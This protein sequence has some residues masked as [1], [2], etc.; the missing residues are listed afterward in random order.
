MGRLPWILPV[1]LVVLVVVGSAAILYVAYQNN[2]SLTRQLSDSRVRTGELERKTTELQD[3]NRDLEGQ[4]L[5][6]NQ[7]AAQLQTRVGQ[8]EAELREPTKTIWNVAQILE[9]PDSYLAGG[10]PDTFTYHLR[11]RSDAPISVSIISFGQF[12]MAIDCVRL[13]RGNTHYCMHHSGGTNWQDIT[14]L[15]YDF[16]DSEGCA[17]YMSVIT[18]VRRVTVTPDVSV[19][20]PPAPRPTGDCAKGP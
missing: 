18:A 14:T 12:A 9:G 19:T 10:V 17:S 16:H 1:A 6:A 20:Y 3:R 7:Q 4:V 11:L 2:A 5:A 8:L 13:A 15:S